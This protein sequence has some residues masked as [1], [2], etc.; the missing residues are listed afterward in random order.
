MFRYI[1]A[2][3]VSL[4]PGR[5]VLLTIRYLGSSLPGSFATVRQRLLTYRKL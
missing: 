4:P 1:Y 5:F 2:C 3:F